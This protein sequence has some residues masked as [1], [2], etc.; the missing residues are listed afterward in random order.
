MD[1]V[2]YRGAR[3]LPVSD[4]FVRRRH[5][6]GAGFFFNKICSKKNSNVNRRL[7]YPFQ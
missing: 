2:I 7:F 4:G 1:G 5:N 3:P 6:A